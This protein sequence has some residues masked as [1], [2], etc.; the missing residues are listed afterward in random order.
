MKR[1]AIILICLHQAVAVRELRRKDV[2]P[3]RAIIQKTYN[4]RSRPVARSDIDVGP[5]LILTSYIEQNKLAEAREAAAVDSKY[6]LPG[7]DSYSGYF[8]VNKQY[9]ANL[10]FW[11]FPVMDQPVEDTPWLIWL[12]GGPGS[13]SLFGLFTEIGPFTFEDNQL[14]EM[15]YSW[16]KNHSL[17]FIDNPVGTGYSFTDDDLGYATNQTTIGENLYEGLQQFLTVFPELRKAPLTI[18]GES[19]AGKYIPALGVQILWHKHDGAHINLH[20]LAMGNGFTDPITLMSLNKVVREVGLVDDHV[21]NVVEKIEAT[22][23]EWLKNEEYENPYLYYNDLL[24]L[25]VTTANVSNVYNYLAEAIELNGPFQDFVQ[26]PEVRHALHVGNTTF[27]KGGNVLNKLIPEYMTS[28]KPWLEQLLEHYK[29]LVYN[30]HLD[31]MV[32][33]K[34]SVSTYESLK[35]SGASEYRNAKRQPWYH[36]GII[37]GYARKGGNLLEVMVRDA[38]HMVPIDK[39]APALALITAFVRDISLDKDTAWL[40]PLE[41]ASSALRSRSVSLD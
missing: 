33:Y 9:N 22:A 28:V 36:D 20:G 30:G 4:I 11:Y 2:E 21:A 25:I 34:P 18:A 13:T 31:L 26:T 10:W 1:L 17:L 7:I 39:P 15:M 8:T 19:Y 23:V 12:Q 6:L 37:A 5:P 24:D 16:G 40:V 3:I 38:G 35:Y 14:K 29:V 32:P 41:G 27:S